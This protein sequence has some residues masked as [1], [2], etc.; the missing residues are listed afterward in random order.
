MTLSATLPPELTIYTIGEL[1]AQWVD[2]L[3]DAEADDAV[4][5]VDTMSVDAAAVAEADAAGVQL[6]LSLRK[7][8]GQRQRRL[9]LASPHPSLVRACESLGVGDLLDDANDHGADR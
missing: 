8:L 7:A 3:R 9:R 6:L 1:Q 2:W 4:A 5:G